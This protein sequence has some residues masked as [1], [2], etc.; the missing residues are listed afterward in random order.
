MPTDRTSLQELER[1]LSVLDQR[2]NRIALYQRINAMAGLNG[3]RAAASCLLSR[4]DEEPGVSRN[5]LAE[6]LKVPASDLAPS[7]DQLS[8]RGL[9][10]T[11]PGEDPE[12]TTRLKALARE[13][14]HEDT[15]SLND[16][17]LRTAA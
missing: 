7:I 13:Y 16:D 6:Q 10:S 12:L 5:T 9:V 8:G 1:A 17:E 11:P 15:R 3:L 4:I 14:V 2:A